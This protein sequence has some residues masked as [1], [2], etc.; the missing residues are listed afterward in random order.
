MK[1]V[2][3]L[4]ENEVIHFETEEQSKRLCDLFDNLGLKWRTGDSYK[5]YTPYYPTNGRYC[6][7]PATGEICTLEFYK[8][9][10]YIIHKA[11]DFLNN[12]DMEKRNI[13]LDINTA[14]EWYNSDN[15]TLKELA[16]QTFPELSKKQHPKR[17]EDCKPF[18]GAYILNYTSEIINVSID[19][20]IESQKF[21]FKTREQAEASLAL[22]QLSILRDE[23][24]QGWL[25]DWENN[26]QLK[27]CIIL[28]NKKVKLD[29]LYE[30]NCFLSFQTREIAQEF[31]NNFK[32]LI[33]QAKPLMS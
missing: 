23:Y 32:E 31:L 7:K 33:E 8:S 2:L 19:K 9:N 10:G 22:A 28:K 12:N 4:K 29:E 17:W 5:D 27:H 14:K 18:R 13:E 21:I 26:T 20:N 25:P 24:R 1:N 15:E 3:D 11:T 6:Y 16:L 30:T